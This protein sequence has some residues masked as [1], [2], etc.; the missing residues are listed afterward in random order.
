MNALSGTCVTFLDMVIIGHIPVFA[1]CL[2]IPMP[3]HWMVGYVLFLNTWISLLHC[4]GSRTDKV[5]WG[6]GIFVHP[7]DHAAH[8]KYGR[9]NVNYG[10]L[11]TFWDR[12][13]GTHQKQDHEN[14]FFIGRTKSN[15]PQ[16]PLL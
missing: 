13:M 1:P 11:L 2:I 3:W 14:F 8:H 7:H 12:L 6:Y 16:Q 5:F 4:V 9:D 10:I 15:L